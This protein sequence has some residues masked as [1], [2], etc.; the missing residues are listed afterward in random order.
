[1]IKTV[2]QML[3]IM[4]IIWYIFIFQ[5][6]RLTVSIIQKFRNIFIYE[7]LKESITT[8]LQNVNCIIP[9]GNQSAWMCPL[10]NERKDP[11]LE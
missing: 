7:K 11:E 1:M 2:F 8:T 4:L 9:Q 3:F 10:S 5:R 6:K